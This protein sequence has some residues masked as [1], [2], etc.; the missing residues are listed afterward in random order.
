MYTCTA[1]MNSIRN[2]TCTRDVT[3]INNKELS[4][5]WEICRPDNHRKARAMQI[6]G[7]MVNSVRNDVTTLLRCNNYQTFG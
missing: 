6:D 2:L 1:F 7:V 4:F 3:Q 5:D